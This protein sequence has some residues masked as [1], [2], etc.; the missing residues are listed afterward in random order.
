MKG[1][2]F[3]KLVEFIEQTWGC[4][5]WD[6]LLCIV[7]FSSG[8]IFTLVWLRDDHTKQLMQLIQLIQNNCEHKGDIKCVLQVNQL[9]V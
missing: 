2:L 6:D 8:G 1:I 3:I 4:E 7:N 5:F 9:I